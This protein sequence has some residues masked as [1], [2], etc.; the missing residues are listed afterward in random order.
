MDIPSEGPATLEY[1]DV[2]A[3]AIQI[4]GYRY[5]EP[6]EPER[7]P[8]VILRFIDRRNWS[9]KNSRED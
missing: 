4:V 2:V 1:D 3:V 7:A 5:D 8:E 6:P 9:R